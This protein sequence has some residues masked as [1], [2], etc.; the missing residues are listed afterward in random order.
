MTWF[1][2][3][4]SLGTMHV[5]S[6]FS[7]IDSGRWDF[8]CI[9]SIVF[10]AN[11]KTDTYLLL[12]VKLMPSL[13]TSQRSSIYTINLNIAIYK[14]TVPRPL[15][16]HTFTEWTLMWWVQKNSSLH[17]VPF[18]ISYITTLRSQ[19]IASQY[20]ALGATLCPTSR[21][22]MMSLPVEWVIPN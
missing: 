9:R 17:K 3:L 8:F 5:T 12:C 19:N 20:D 22:D 16:T 21:S 2:P 11:C 4:S 6:I 18:H 7:I 15:F 1:F 10:C 14:D 13:E